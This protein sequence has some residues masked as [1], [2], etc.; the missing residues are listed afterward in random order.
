MKWSRKGL[1]HNY[2]TNCYLLRVD[3]SGYNYKAEAC[4]ICGS[5]SWIHFK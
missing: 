4:P 3:K 5:G 1:G 2:C